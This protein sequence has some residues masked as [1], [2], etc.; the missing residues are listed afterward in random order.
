MYK[1]MEENDEA[2]PDGRNSKAKRATSQTG[3]HKRD[4]QPA[5]DVADVRITDL[6]AIL[7][8]SFCNHYSM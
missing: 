6:T 8:L 5:G 3:V 4:L 2:I 7:S 1:K